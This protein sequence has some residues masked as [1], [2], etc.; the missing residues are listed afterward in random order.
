MHMTSFNNDTTKAVLQ[1]LHT[2]VKEGKN[3]E[4]WTH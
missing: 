1:V 4:S 2:W 3:L